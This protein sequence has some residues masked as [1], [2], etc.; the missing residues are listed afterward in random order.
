MKYIAAILS[1][2]VHALIVLILC[3]NIFPT[4][5]NIVSMIDI[6]LVSPT[7]LKKVKLD[8]KLEPVIQPEKKPAKQTKRPVSH[9]KKFPSKKN[10]NNSQSKVKNKSSQISANTA[11]MA[12]TVQSKTLLPKKKQQVP[13]SSVIESKDAQNRNAITLKQGKL[14]TVGNETIALKRGS[15]GRTFDT[16]AA[17]SFN[18]DDFH[19]HYETETGRD[20]SIID[21]RQE[22]GRLV[23][24]DKENRFD[25]KTQKSRLRRIYLYLRSVL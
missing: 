2:F 3:N 23:L 24:H 12:G 17:Y 4:P 8:Q 20:I 18:E 16:L 22:Q 9:Q 11:N 14:V 1:I 6:E 5:E 10:P 19:G 25:Q 21:A 7:V 15:E 13:V